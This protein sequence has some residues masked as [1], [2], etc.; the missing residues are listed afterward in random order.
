MLA[1]VLILAAI[2]SG[3]CQ[4]DDILYVDD[5]RIDREAVEHLR[6][7]ERL[8][9]TRMTQ[10]NALL[11]A[12]RRAAMVAVGMR[13]GIPVL[14]SD[15]YVRLETIERD[16]KDL[17][18]LNET[19]VLIGDEAYLRWV[20]DP[21]FVEERLEQVF[22]EEQH[23]L[24]TRRVN[25]VR[26]GVGE[27]LTVDQLAKKY[28]W[29][30][31]VRFQL[32]PESKT[33]HLLPILL[34]SYEDDLARFK[35]GELKAK[36]LIPVGLVDYVDGLGYHQR[37]YV[38]ALVDALDKGVDGQFLGSP[39]RE[40]DSLLILRRLSVQNGVYDAEGLRLPLQPFPEWLADRYAE[41]AVDQCLLNVL[42]RAREMAPNSAIVELL[43]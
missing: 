30:S 41:L 1:L 40:P 8:N 21:I 10:A 5:L 7:S 20:V 13:S 24:S 9:G 18:R 6:T 31:L 42:T 35:K 23:R 14:E 3:R 27:G 39:V 29:L 15:R 4:P 17:R 22:E 34:K 33:R 36:P 37:G 2:P 28:R 43:K 19:R 32:E 38:G 11:V 26:R 12:M 16:T 25:L